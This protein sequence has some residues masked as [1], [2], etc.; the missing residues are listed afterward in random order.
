MRWDE[1][2]RDGMVGDEIRWEVRRNRR[3]IIWRNREGK[4]RSKTQLRKRRDERWIEEEEENKRETAG[5]KIQKISSNKRNGA[6][7]ESIG[8]EG[9]VKK[10]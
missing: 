6:Q 10:E 2:R 4:K 1:M 7:H 9:N 5:R 3:H 8:E